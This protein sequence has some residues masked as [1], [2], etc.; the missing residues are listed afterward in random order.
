MNVEKEL[1]SVKPEK[2]TVFTIGV[3]DGVHIGHQHLFNH[4]RDRAQEGGYLSGV[5]TFKTH[6]EAVINLASQPWIYD[7]ET[8]TRLIKGLGI[9]IVVTLD[10]TRDLMQLDAVDFVQLLLKH[11]KLKGLVVGPDFALGKNREGNIEKLRR[12]GKEKHFSLEVMAPFMQDGEIVS[13]SIIRQMV[14]RGN[15]EKAARFLG[16]PFSIKGVPVPGEHRGTELGFPTIN[17]EPKPDMASPSNGVYATIAKVGRKTIPSVTNL[18]VKPTFG[19]NRRL[20]ETHLIGHKG[21][22]EAKQVEIVF[23]AR[24]R[25]ELK[26]SSAGELKTQIAKD[27]EKAKAILAKTPGNG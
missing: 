6:P 8:R 10:F 22:V 17:L 13:S 2:D 20:Y 1:A 23:V 14:A 7:L 5:I 24:L 11:L 18:G 3:F 15:V 25:D 26:F 19:D 27:I 16:R 12:L 9:D 4:L 21:E